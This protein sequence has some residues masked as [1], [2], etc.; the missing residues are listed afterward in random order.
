MAVLF[1]LVKYIIRNAATPEFVTEGN[2]PVAPNS[3]V[4]KAMKGSDPVLRITGDISKGSETFKSKTLLINAEKYRHPETRNSVSGSTITITV[5]EFKKGRR[6]AVRKVNSEAASVKAL[7]NF[8]KVTP[9]AETSAPVE[10]AKANSET[11]SN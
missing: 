6:N 1:T 5:P 11:T 2:T 10:T 7:A 8:F 9:N 3:S 4:V